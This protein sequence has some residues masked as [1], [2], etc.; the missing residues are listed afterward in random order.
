MTHLKA[1]DKAPDFNCANEKG[2]MVSLSDFSGKKLVLY[3]YPKDNTPGC[4][5][6]SC[7][8][9]DNYHKFL[10]QGYQVLGVSADSMKKHQNFIKKFELPF[11]LL[12]DTDTEVCKAYGVWGPKKLFGVNYVGINRTTFIIDEK[13]IIE[14]VIDDVDTGNHTAQI[15]G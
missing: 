10:S 12:A 3:F 13:G 15:L 7:N 6:E 4:T 2:E 9:R 5:I 8:L 11:P 14:K 1:G